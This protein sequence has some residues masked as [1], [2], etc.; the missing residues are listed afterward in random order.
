MRAERATDR[1]G[2]RE[3]WTERKMGLSRERGKEKESLGRKKNERVQSPGLIEKKE[4]KERKGGGEEVMRQEGE[5]KEMGEAR[6]E[7]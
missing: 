4:K 1:G 7:R 5:S 6:I 2:R 3:E